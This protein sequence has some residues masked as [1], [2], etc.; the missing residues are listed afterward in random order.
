MEAVFILQQ[1]AE[2]SET[3]CW[4]WYVSTESR[5]TGQDLTCMLLHAELMRRY[6]GLL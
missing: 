2:T 1:T 6:V 5:R 4:L 3:G